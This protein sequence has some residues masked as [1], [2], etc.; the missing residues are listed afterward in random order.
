M[1][2]RAF[3]T[4]LGTVLVMPRAAEAQPAVKIPR[5]GF[6]SSGNRVP[7]DHPY[8]AAIR[9]GLQDAG[10]VLGQSILVDWEFAENDHKRL[11][12]LVARMIRS[13]VDV[14]LCATSSD[15]IAAKNATKTIPIVMLGTGDP[16]GVGFVQSL[17]R[18][19]GNITGLS[20]NHH[21]LGP[22]RLQ[23]LR[24]IT[25]KTSR[26]GVLSAKANAGAVL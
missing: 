14:F 9:D 4:G 13:H 1:N 12:A 16:V 8:L 21:E 17:A 22:K 2:R 20:P 10:Y 25:Q 23:L 18:P 11:P 24:E 19:G 7:P 26:I 6:L 15:V 5:V 3:V